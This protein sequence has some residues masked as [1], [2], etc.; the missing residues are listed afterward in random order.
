MTTKTR[1]ISIGNIDK[2]S[3]DNVYD[4]LNY[5]SYSFKQT[6]PTYLGAI[7]RMFGMQTVDPTKARV[8]EMG[9]AAGMNIIPLACA[10]KDAEFI[11][12]DLSKTQ[13]DE[14]KKYTK[15]LK[16]KNIEFKHMSITDLDDSMGKFDYI[17]VHGIYSWVPENVRNSILENGKKLLSDNGILYVSYNALPGW[18][19]VKSIRDMMIYHS[20]NFTSPQDK[21]MQAKAMLNFVKDQLKDAD[22]PYAKFLT[23][24]LNMLQNQ[25][26][27][28]VFHDH[29]ENNNN[30][31][32][33]HEFVSD[34]KSH[35][36]QYLGDTSL[37]SMYMG[38]YGESFSGAISQIQDIVRQEQYM[39]FVTN[40][41]F[42]STLLC[43]DNLVL[44]RAIGLNSIKDLYFQCKL[45]Q[46]SKITK[47][48]LM[49]DT[50]EIEFGFIDNTKDNKIQISGVEM[51]HAFNFIAT[52][53]IEYFNMDEIF[54][55]T[56]KAI[57]ENGGKI[58]EKDIFINSF[59]NIVLKL[60]FSGLCY[61]SLDK[62]S[63][64]NEIKSDKPK[65]WDVALN[66]VEN[67]FQRV[68]NKLHETFNPN[69]MEGKILFYAN[70]NRTID[71][72]AEKLLEHFRKG[73]LT[74]KLDD[75]PMNIQEV[76]KNVRTW[77][78][79]TLNNFAVRALLD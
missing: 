46:I 51:K 19:M 8:L 70:G 78:Q 13:I 66:Q 52:R 50:K 55:N 65:I 31:F 35:G 57:E 44:N 18:N 25:R 22:S 54:E 4:Q 47:E 60:V 63:F 21:I 38:N 53:G 43:K 34:A 2:P 42:R 11:G 26:D 28:Y 79:N 71:E 16:L 14:A 7:G 30:Q 64:D 76:E 9:C 59:T 17:I 69:M 41:R 10:Y 72:I 37:A 67:N 20:S 74:A 61:V 24:E 36:L 40:R 48:D 73:D 45:M 23:Q 5:E 62:M 33:L 39:D 32:Y 1:N 3:Q 6:A 77:V 75:K 27:S 68:T 56:K 12:I 29:M 15:E 49:S 58:G